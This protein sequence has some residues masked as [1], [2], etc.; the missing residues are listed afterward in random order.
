[1]NIDEIIID[2]EIIPVDLQEKI[3]KMHLS[4]DFPWYLSFEQTQTANDFYRK[5]FSLITPNISEYSQFVHVFQIDSRINSS[6]TFYNP[7]IDIFN[8]C[9][10]KYKFKNNIFRIKSNFCPKVYEKNLDAHQIPHTDSKENHWIMLYYIN[11]SDGDTFIFN[12]KNKEDEPIY[13][14]KTLTVKK[15]ISPKQGRVIIFNGDNLHAGMHPRDNFNR[16]VINF[17]FSK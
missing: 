6:E 8:I 7:V 9:K 10:N 17:V 2:D 14:I 3:K 1:M 11:D 12:E 4:D 5:Y 15:R 13:N 16:L